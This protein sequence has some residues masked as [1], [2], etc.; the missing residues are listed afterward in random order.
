MNK[1]SLQ[2]F[3]TKTQNYTD[4][5]VSAA[6]QTMDIV[7]LSDFTDTTMLTRF[8]S[9]VNRKAKILMYKESRATKFTDVDHSYVRDAWG[10]LGADGKH[11]VDVKYG[12]VLCDVTKESYQDYLAYYIAGRV[13]IGYDGVFLDECFIDPA[14]HKYSQ[15]IPQMIKDGW[16]Q[17]I[18]NIVRKTKGLMGDRLVVPNCSNIKS[19][20]Q[21][22]RYSDALFNEE[23]YLNT[24]GTAWGT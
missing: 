19:N 11:I 3:Y 7:V 4:A 1:L 22:A 24:I 14:E 2:T 18:N 8:K 9:V 10:I 6:A 12:F 23:G 13:R 15:P 20:L 16:E 21:L 17:G 5:Q